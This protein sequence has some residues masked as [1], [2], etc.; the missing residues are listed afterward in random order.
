MHDYKNTFVHIITDN[1]AYFGYV[2]YDFDPDFIR[3]TPIEWGNNKLDEDALKTSCG[4]RNYK[5]VYKIRPFPIDIRK[6]L[7]RTIYILPRI[8]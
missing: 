2:E 4:D 7:I 8:Y 3:V 1:D 5:D 6:S